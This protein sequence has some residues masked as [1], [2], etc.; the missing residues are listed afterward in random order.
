MNRNRHLSSIPRVTMPIGV[1]G[2]GRGLRIQAGAE[3]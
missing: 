3:L 2:R 1:S